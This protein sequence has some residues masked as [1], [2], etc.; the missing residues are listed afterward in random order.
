MQDLTETVKQIYAAINQNN[1]AKVLTYFDPQITRIEPNG[2]TLHG[3]TELNAHFVE[4]RSNWEEG[5]CQ[6]ERLI[7]AG[8]KFVALVYVRVK[9]KNKVELA[10]GHIADGFIFRNGKVIEMRTFI[11]P[12]EALAWAGVKE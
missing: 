3:S 1:I 12:K 5:S 7:S 6:P 8:D 9:L 4:A 2:L 11:E 10:E